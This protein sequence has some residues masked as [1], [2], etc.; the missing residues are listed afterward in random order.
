ML[1]DLPQPLPD[2]LTKRIVLQQVMKIYYLLGL[3]SPFTLIG[4]IYLRGSWARNLGWD[5]QLHFD[6]RAKWVK[7]FIS[8]LELEKLNL[9]RCLRPPNAV[10][11]TWLV[12]LSD[13]SDVAYGFVAYIRWLLGDGDTWYRLI[14]A[15]CRVGPVISYRLRRW[16]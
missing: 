4:K 14:M 15:K 2:I 13:G 5:D 8:L 9:P 3:V 1:P 12:I 7:F 10:G 6:L 11:E 16:S